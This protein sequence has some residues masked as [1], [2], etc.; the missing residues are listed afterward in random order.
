MLLISRDGL[1][2]ADYEYSNPKMLFRFQENLFY[3]LHWDLYLTHFEIDCNILNL[4]FYV[5]YTILFELLP[6]HTN[7]SDRDVRL[8]E[9][10]SRGFS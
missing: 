2:F 5:Y 3:K 9:L 7:D 1:H 4:Y 8:H 10:L 6:V